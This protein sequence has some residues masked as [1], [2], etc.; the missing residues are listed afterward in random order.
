MSKIQDRKIINNKRFLKRVVKKYRKLVIIQSPSDDEINQ[1]DQILELAIYNDEL[2]DLINKIDLEL[3]QNMFIT[4]ITSDSENIDVSNNMSENETASLFTNNVVMDYNSYPKTLNSHLLSEKIL[5]NSQ[6]LIKPMETLFIGGLIGGI[7]LFMGLVNPCYENLLLTLSNVSNMERHD[8]IRHSIKQSNQKTDHLN[9]QVISLL[10]LN[11]NSKSLSLNNKIESNQHRSYER[12]QELEKQYTN[13]EV[14]KTYNSLNLLKIRISNI[15]PP[16]QKIELTRKAE[17]IQLKAESKQKEA[18][19]KQRKAE[20]KQRKAEIKKHN[21][22]ATYWHK[23]AKIY[24][25][26]SQ[27]WLDLAQNSVNIVTQL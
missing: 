5:G 8:G 3:E 4:S 17:Q 20:S 25:K 13:P 9:N 23:Q 16:L 22:L 26:E 6:S 19:F 7:L 14:Q 24:L 21:D 11:N 2:N 27:E 12:S 1:I 18:E 15:L 10:T